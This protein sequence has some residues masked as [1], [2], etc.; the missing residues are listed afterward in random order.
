M[1]EIPIVEDADIQQNF[2]LTL[3][4]MPLLKKFGN[5]NPYFNSPEFF[6]RVMP[7][8]YTLFIYNPVDHT[9]QAYI[10][11]HVDADG[12]E[13][14]IPN[15]L[16]LQ[17]EID[18]GLASAE[19]SLTEYYL[20]IRAEVDEFMSF[21]LINSGIMRTLDKIPVNEDAVI[22]FSFNALTSSIPHPEFHHDGTLFQLLTYLHNTQDYV[23][24]SEL[25]LYPVSDFSQHQILDA[26]PQYIGK[27]ILNS[28]MLAKTCSE[29]LV[30]AGIVNPPIL[31]GKYHNGDSLV[32]PDYFWKHAVINPGENIT[33]NL[34]HI[35]TLDKSGSER[36]AAKAY[37]C[38]ERIKTTQSEWENR[39]VIALFCSLLLPP[40]V[41][42]GRLMTPFNIVA[43]VIDV[44][45]VH[46]FGTFS[47]FK[48]LVELSKGN[49]VEY[50]K[51]KPKDGI[52]SIISR[53]IRK[54]KKK[55]RRSKGRGNKGNK[56]TR[57]SYKKDNKTKD[58]KY[59]KSR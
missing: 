59:K 25:V 3:D 54:T 14:L 31:R 21:Q 40:N 33:D 57:Q 55:K 46:G 4:G 41:E 1:E 36:V 5:P 11:T 37:V 2:C 19:L 18:T 29:L 6:R 49:C 23:L 47:L 16:V 43:Q 44:P 7:L 53:G 45:T 38:N 9:L 22:A 12:N 15:T 8:K 39:S 35:T 13:I 34:L 30:D 58:K 26:G 56:T 24:G 20:Q 32:W 52:F 42:T 10:T 28:A 17:T 48:L 51:K 50:N 27:E